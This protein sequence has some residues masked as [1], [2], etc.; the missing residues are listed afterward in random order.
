LVGP[1]TADVSVVGLGGG[2]TDNQEIARLLDDEVLMALQ[3]IFVDIEAR[4]FA[5]KPLEFRDRDQWHLMKTS[6]TSR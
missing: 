6:R 1:G 4:R 5:E 2:L 3:V